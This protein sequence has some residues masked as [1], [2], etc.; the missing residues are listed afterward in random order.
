MYHN[1]LNSKNFLWNIS[2][3]KNNILFLL[4]LFYKL[5][6]FLN[7]KI[8]KCSIDFSKLTTYLQN[9]DF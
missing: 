5:E 4:I 7:Q 6:N 2:S 8:H 3:Y 9:I 1:V